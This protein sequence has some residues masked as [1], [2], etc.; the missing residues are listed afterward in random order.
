[1]LAEIERIPTSL[2]LPESTIIF[3]E[4]DPADCFFLIASGGV[5]ISKRGR[6]GRQESL[7]QFGADDFFGEMAIY[8]PAPR[9]ARAA[10]TQATRLGRVDQEGFRRMIELAPLEISSNLTRETI[11]RLRRMD[12]LL[13]DEL[14]EAERLSLVGTMASSIIHDF[15]N[16]MAVIQ[17]AVQMLERRSEDPALTKYAGMIRRSVDRMMSMAHELLDYSRGVTSLDLRP[18]RVE[19]LF[20]ELEEQ[21]LHLLPASGIHV[22]RDIGFTGSIMIDRNRFIRMLLNIIRNAAEAMGP[23]GVLRIG[24]AR[25]GTEIRFTVEDTGGGIPEEILPTIFE[26]FVTHGKS[27][28]TGLGMAIARAVADAHGGRIT[29]SSTPGVGTRVDISLPES[30]AAPATT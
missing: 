14:M 6:G 8:D 2:D 19:E 20:E 5:R 23:A 21:A 15:R 27:G 3:Q 16:P 1:M 4:G 18:V 9:S 24:V 28:G 12:S 13:I 17:G 7:S 25:A 29:I 10:S 30:P 26:P 22:E 11:R